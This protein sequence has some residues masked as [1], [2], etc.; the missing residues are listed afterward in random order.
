[1]IDLLDISTR[2]GFLHRYTAF[3]AAEKRPFATARRRLPNGSGPSLN[4]SGDGNNEIN[5]DAEMPSIGDI[6]D[7]SGESVSEV[8]DENNFDQDN[9]LEEVRTGMRAGSKSQ[10]KETE[11]LQIRHEKRDSKR[12]KNEPVFT[13]DAGTL[14]LIF[15]VR[16][17]T[18][19]ALFKKN[20]SRKLCR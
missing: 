12:P 18:L 8:Y 19:G 11:R 15:K 2:N 7:L 16:Y 5:G 17:Q 13:D 1:M 14:K 10:T 3:I 9:Y 4:A 20:F 6:H